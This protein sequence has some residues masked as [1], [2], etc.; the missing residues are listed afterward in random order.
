MSFIIVSFCIGMI[1]LSLIIDRKI[2][3]PSV[4]FNFWWGLTIF[5]SGFGFFGIEV[6]NNETY[7]L[8][9]IAIISFNIPTVLIRSKRVIES[10]LAKSGSE[11]NLFFNSNTVR[12]LSIFQLF[13]IGILGARS[14]RVLNLL[15]QGNPYSNIRYYYY[16]SELI[17]TA[18][19]GMLLTNAFITP[20]VLLGVIIV[21]V[22]L[23]NKQKNF[24]LIIL[25]ILSMIL[26]SFSSGGR[27]IIMYFIVAII[28]IFIINGMEIKYNFRTKL[29]INSMV[30]LFLLLLVY[31]S[32]IR[33]EGDTALR[34]LVKTVLVYFTGSFIYFEKMLPVLNSNNIVLYGATFFGGI[35]DLVILLLN[36]LGSN[37]VQ[38]SSYISEFNQNYVNIGGNT[39]F[40][41][42]TTMLYPFIYD[43]GLMGIIIQPFLFGVISGYYYLRMEAKRS[44]LYKSIYL[45][46]ILMI[47]ESVMRWM[48]L[49]MHTWIVIFMF[50]LL[51]FFSLHS[52]KRKA[53]QDDKKDN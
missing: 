35:Q 47:Y 29:F 21:A 23:F 5:L 24:K 37:F 49:F 8:F 50:Y 39:L 2:Y 48:G 46:I 9:L 19:Y 4:I 15:L 33:A 13:T 52:M 25:S 7:T 17:V 20:M 6:P 11:F 41:A 45:I 31:I 30:L 44:I 43:F 27:G 16:N 14:I 51:K 38:I 34:D 12:W 36:S 53:W 32:L 3:N 10:N 22:S 26:L 1:I 18:S 28:S 42:F 40:N